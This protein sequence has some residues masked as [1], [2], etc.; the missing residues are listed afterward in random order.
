V[1][2]DKVWLILL[3]DDSIKIY[4]SVISKYVRSHGSISKK[5]RIPV[6]FI[7][8]GVLQNGLFGKTFTASCPDIVWRGVVLLPAI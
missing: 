3:R 4:H 5:G 8:R 7:D 6:G 1:Q 2:N